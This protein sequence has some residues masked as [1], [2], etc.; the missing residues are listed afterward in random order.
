MNSKITKRYFILL[1]VILFHSEIYA[2]EFDP[3]TDIVIDQSTNIAYGAYGAPYD[4]EFTC[5]RDIKKKLPTI[6]RKF[7]NGIATGQ[8]F[9]FDDKGIPKWVIVYRNGKRWKVDIFA[10]RYNQPKDTKLPDNYRFTACD[11][12]SWTKNWCDNANFKDCLPD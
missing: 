10:K 5:Y 12:S 9:C 4:G 11:A 2:S 7:D 8:H 3:C 1:V 6:K